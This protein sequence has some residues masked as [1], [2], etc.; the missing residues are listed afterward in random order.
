MLDELFVKALDDRQARGAEAR[1]RRRINV[2]L[3]DA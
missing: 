3:S 2:A 1:M